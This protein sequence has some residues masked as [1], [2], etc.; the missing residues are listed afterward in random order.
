MVREHVTLLEIE[1]ILCVRVRCG[2]SKC[3]QELL[4][5]LDNREPCLPLNC[6]QCNEPW[7]TRGSRQPPELRLL[8]ALKDLRAG[9]ESAMTIRLESRMTDSLR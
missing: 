4:I 8:Q 5:Q 2:G 7:Y 3:H 9:A 1:D 6:P